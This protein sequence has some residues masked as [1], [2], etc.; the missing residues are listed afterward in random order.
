MDKTNKLMELSNG[1]KFAVIKQFKEP[2][3]IY[4]FTVGVNEAEDDITNEYVF[5]KETIKDGRTFME[6]VVDPG[7]ISKFKVTEEDLENL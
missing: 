5:F 4:Y 3:G 1:E 2:D 6:E 7:I